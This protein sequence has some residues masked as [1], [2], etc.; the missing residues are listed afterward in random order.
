MNTLTRVLPIAASFALLS[1]RSLFALAAPKLNLP[2]GYVLPDDFK[3]PK[4]IKIPSGF[5][6]TPEMIEEYMEYLDEE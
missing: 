5:E 2:K 6:I 1:P 4:G 3:L